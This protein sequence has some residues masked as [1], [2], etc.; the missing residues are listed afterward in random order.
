MA[1]EILQHGDEKTQVEVIKQFVK[2]A[3]K[4]YT[5]YHN[6]NGMMEILSGLELTPVQRLKKAWAQ[7]PIRSLGRIGKLR[8]IMQTEGNFRRYRSEL[9]AINEE[10]TPKI[11]YMPIVLKDFTF[12]EEGNAKYDEDGRVN[13]D[14]L[15]LLSAQ[16]ANIKRMQQHCF[17]K[18]KQGVT[19]GMRRYLANLNVVQDD[20]ELHRLSLKRQPKLPQRKRSAS[21]GDL[22]QELNDSTT[23]QQ[24]KA[25]NTISKASTTSNSSSS[26]SDQNMTQKISEAKAAWEAKAKA[27]QQEFMNQQSAKWA[28][29]DDKMKKR[30]AEQTTSLHSSINL[31]GVPLGSLSSSGGLPRSSR[32][33]VLVSQEMARILDKKQPTQV[34]PVSPLTPPTPLSEGVTTKT[35]TTTPTNSPSKKPRDHRMQKS[36]SEFIKPRAKSDDDMSKLEAS[37]DLIKRINAAEESSSSSKKKQKEF[38]DPI[39][40]GPIVKARSD[41]VITKK[42]G[43]DEKE[44][45]KREEGE[46]KAKQGRKS[47][48][49]G[50]DVSTM[51][52]PPQ[53]KLVKKKKTRVK[54]VRRLKSAPLNSSLEGEE[55]G[56]EKEKE[57]EEETSG[58]IEEKNEKK[59]IE[60]KK[61]KEGKH[62]VTFLVVGQD[63]RNRK[64]V[65]SVDISFDEFLEKVGNCQSKDAEA[66]ESGETRGAGLQTFM[67]ENENEEKVKVT[68]EEDFSDF[69][70][71][72]LQRDKEYNLVWPF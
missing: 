52:I 21:D 17:Y 59:K 3:D 57:K 67:Y 65:V 53:R 54:K 11:P 58:E 43:V 44:E 63:G 64:C 6:F 24:Q 23:Q 29:F 70:E 42:K 66:V 51:T 32:S 2:I 41:G 40:D 35:T 28:S 9:A 13:V 71:F 1:T 45:E 69:F 48:L 20:E 56:K 36:T 37:K 62:T 14:R 4:I 15:Q 12:I 34:Q 22:S 10:K 5:K 60:K 50:F 61:R 18:K 31:S 46:A 25:N 16:L 38:D 26:K 8:S 47:S 27:G 19:E 68:N 7:V 49:E 39:G 33:Q 55:E 30:S 72:S